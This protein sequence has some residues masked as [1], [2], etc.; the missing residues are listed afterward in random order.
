MIKLYVTYD[1][2]SNLYSAP[3]S[4]QNDGCA[5]RW[6]KNSLIQ[7]VSKND[8]SDYELYCIGCYDDKTAVC[9][10]GKPILI[11]K[12]LTVFGENTNIDESMEVEKDEKA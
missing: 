2:V 4:L 8:Y 9:T 12:G 5:K 10:V 3:L 6:F 1:K 7:S 11:T